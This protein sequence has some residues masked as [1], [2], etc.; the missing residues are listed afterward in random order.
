[1]WRI[2]S[3]INLV[4]NTVCVIQYRSNSA[5][6]K[7]HSK[8]AYSQEMEA[9]ALAR[10]EGMQALIGLHTHQDCP[11][12][13]NV[14]T[15]VQ[16]FV[17]QFNKKFHECALSSDV[18]RGREEMGG[19]IGAQERCECNIVMFVDLSSE[20]KWGSSTFPSTV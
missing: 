8:W 15:G 7:S 6:I 16:V 19:V 10:N 4:L 9:K 1:M 12:Y 17:K 18:Q 13:W 5:T 11:V 20:Y 3:S 14:H 2:C